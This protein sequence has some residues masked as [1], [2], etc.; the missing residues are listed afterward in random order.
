MLLPNDL[1]IALACLAVLVGL[2]FW[3]MRSRRA[4]KKA[5]PAEWALTS[6]S[7]F[8]IEERR[9]YRHLCASLPDNIVL[10][11]LPL[12]RFCQPTDTQQVRYWYELLGVIHVTFA[13]CTGS[14]RV[15]AVVDLEGER[16]SS[17]RTLQIKEAVLAA[18][19]VRYLRCLPDALPLAPELQQLVPPPAASRMVSGASPVH[20]TRNK[21]SRIVASRRQ[22]RASRWQDSTLAVQDSTFGGDSLLDPPSELGGVVTDAHGTPLRH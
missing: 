8:S 16:G 12:V 15:V 3:S 19:G 11:K 9:F 1:I 17:R 14:G 7:V 18:C 20:E 6:R 5:M 13:I 10:A 22:E 21:L 2:L 4:K